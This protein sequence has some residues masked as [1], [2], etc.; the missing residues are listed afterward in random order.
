MAP[1]KSYFHL[2]NCKVKGVPELSTTN[3]C[4]AMMRQDDESDLP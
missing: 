1:Y 2:M 4:N 3:P